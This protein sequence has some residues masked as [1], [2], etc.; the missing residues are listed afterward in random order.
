MLESIKKVDK[1]IIIMMGIL[2]AVIA[3]ILIAVLI[4]TLTGG[5]NLSY[6][7]IENKLS[8][9]AESYCKDNDDKLPK[10]LGEEVTI[11]L[12]TLVS[13]G[14]IKDLSEYVDEKVSCNAKVIVGKNHSGYDYV[15][16][17]D[18]GKDYKTIFLAD[19]LK[20]NVV[21]EGPGLYQVSAP[22]VDMG[23]DA[24]GY[25]LS[26]NELMFGYTFRGEKLNNYIQFG[27][28]KSKD[29]Q[30]YKIVKIDGNDDIMV[31][32]ISNTKEKGEYDN[33]YNPETD[34][35]T[36]KNDYTT[37]RALEN[38]GE[39]YDKLDN[40]SIIKQKV[41]T[42]NICIGARAYDDTTKDGTTECRTVMKDQ[43]YSLLPA[44][45]VLNA[46]LEP[47][48][49]TTTDKLCGNYNYLSIGNTYWTST[50]STKNSYTAYSVGGGLSSSP[51]TNQYVYKYA[52]Y[53]SSRLVYVSGTGTS[54]DPYIVK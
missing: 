50:P 25:D 39:I 18:C 30:K 14:Y 20:E 16:A 37:S 11:E 10:K 31:V 26:T 36:G 45:D 54:D 12:A 48:C 52:F 9:A 3:I 29:N 4:L 7:K 40:N 35:K 6:E 8:S 13:A 32:V 49:S 51:V 44:Y 28:K 47:L 43:Y 53:L 41:V 42:K 46:S 24:D 2:I 1:K 38:I 21:T 27:D 15:P 19:K 22:N 17:L 5:R 23:L 33:R 34:E